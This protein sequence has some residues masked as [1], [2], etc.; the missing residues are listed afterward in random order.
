MNIKWN[1]GGGYLKLVMDNKLW[2]SIIYLS[3]AR[4][5]LL[6]MIVSDLNY[7]PGSYENDEIVEITDFAT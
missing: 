7:V 6:I 5:P 3:F 4:V 1:D 2:S